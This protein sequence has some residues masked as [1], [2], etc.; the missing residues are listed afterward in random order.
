MAHLQRPDTRHALT[1]TVRKLS[2]QDLSCSFAEEIVSKAIDLIVR[3][4]IDSPRIDTDAPDRQKLEIHPFV[5]D[6]AEMHWPPPSDTL[7]ASYLQS[8]ET[9]RIAVTAQRVESK[10]PIE[11]VLVDALITFDDVSY[12]EHAD[13]IYDLARQV[14]RHLASYLRH[15]DVVRVLRLHCGNIARLLH[16]QMQ[17]HM[18]RT[19]PN[20]T[21]QVASGFVALK[22]GAHTAPA[23][24]A[25][26][27]FRK[28]PPDLGKISR[29]VFERFSRCLYA[30]QKFQSDP[31]RRL[32]IILD[33]DALKWFKPVRGQMLLSYRART[34]WRDYQPDFLAETAAQILLLEVKALNEMGDADVVAKRDA[35]IAWCTRASAHARTHGGKPWTYALIPD[36]AIT[37]NMTIAGLVDLYGFA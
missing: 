26:L 23:G 6:F 13:L 14:I 19:E 11:D 20:D 24:D 31:E 3:Y 18:W 22:T 17:D 30:I 8:G 32:A 4:S 5:V 2:N 16:A 33:R 21:V 36:Q 27:D 12:D 37:E 28:P 29:H 35:A 15:N 9:E 34:G 1:E 25:P 10:R 7:W